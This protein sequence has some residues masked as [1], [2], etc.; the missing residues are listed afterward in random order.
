MAEELGKIEKPPV[1]NFRTG[2]KLYFIPLI[3]QLEESPEDYLEKCNRYWEQVERQILELESKLGVVKRVY[4][5]LVAASG[6]EGSRTVEEL[7]KG[8]HKIVKLCLEKDARLEAVEDADVFTE[9]MD[10]N[11]CLLVGLQNPGVAAKVYESYIEAGKKRNESIARRIDETL[12]SDEIGIIFMRE[13]HQ[14][15]FPSDIQVFYVAP[16]ALDEIKRWSRERERQQPQEEAKEAKDEKKTRSKK[17][18]K[19]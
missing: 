15:Q 5:E 10:W 18:T 6:K 7:N 11:R 9:F 3:F 2:R 16:P 13:N 14:V 12:Q 4:H 8:S 19:E 17:K 1:E